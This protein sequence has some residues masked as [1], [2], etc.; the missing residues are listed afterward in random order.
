MKEEYYTLQE[1]SVKIKTPV[2]YLRKMIKENK[3]N[4]H[5]MGR[6][7]KVTESELSEY[8]KSCGVQNER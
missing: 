2:A 1:V 3:L 4:A 7:Y 8:V 5:K 6:S